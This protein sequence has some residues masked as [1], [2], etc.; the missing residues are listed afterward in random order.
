MLKRLP[1]R[2]RK[3]RRKEPGETTAGSGQARRSTTVRCD[4]CKQLGH[5]KRT[6]QRAP[7]AS[8]KR[9]QTKAVTTGTMAN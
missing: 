6:C 3:N 7:V 5:N 1:G 4:N 8:R 9:K 2:P